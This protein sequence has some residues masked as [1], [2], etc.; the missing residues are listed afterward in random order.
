MVLLSIVLPCYNPIENWHLTVLK[1]YN[2]IKLALNFSPEIIIVNDGSKKLISP[3]SI[4][5]LKE[6][7]QHFQFLSYEINQGKGAALRHGIETAKGQFIIYTDIDF[8]YETKSLIDIW[9][10]LQYDNDIVIG[11]KDASYYLHVPASRIYISKML[12]ALSHMMLNIPI[13]DTQCGLKGF[14]KKGKAIFLN[15]T[16]NRYLCDLEFV[17]QSYKQQGKLNIITQSIRLREGVI[18]SNMNYKILIPELLNFIKILFK[19]SAP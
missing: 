3:E 8:P 17:Y 18:F 15:T 16:I 5:F 6:N 13:T 14:N 2:Q 10:R 9:Q 19:K 11:V 1:R 12:R 4:S 7:I